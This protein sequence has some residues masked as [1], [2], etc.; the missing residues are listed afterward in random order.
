M[1]G[2]LRLRFRGREIAWKLLD[3]FTV[4]LESYISEI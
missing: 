4:Q 2:V 3:V 1:I